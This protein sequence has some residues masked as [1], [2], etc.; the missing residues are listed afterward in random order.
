MLTP[1]QK[2]IAQKFVDRIYDWF[3]VQNKP[4]A[5]NKDKKECVY[6]GDNGNLRCAIGCNVPDELAQKLQE[7][8]GSYEKLGSKGLK[9]LSPTLSNLIKDSPDLHVL[10]LKDEPFLDQLQI[11]HDYWA[12]HPMMADSKVRYFDAMQ[13]F[14]N[15]YQLTWPEAIPT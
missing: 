13:K 12:V 11:R 1:E 14:C 15:L 9:I 5:F 4:M 8:S 2:V 6:W 7:T 3:F 10:S